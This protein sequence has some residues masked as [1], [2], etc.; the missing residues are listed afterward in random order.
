VLAAPPPS[1]SFG[2]APKARPIPAWGEAP[3]WYAPDPRGL[4][5]RPMPSIPQILLVAFHSILLQERPELILEILLPMMRLLRV[6]ILNQRLQISRTYR[7]RSVSPLPRELRQHRRFGLEPLRRRSLQLRNQLRN[8][9]GSQ[10]PD[11]KMHMVRN[12]SH[13]VALAPGIAND[14]GKVRIQFRT[15]RITQ[16]SLPALRTEDHM[17]HDERK[18]QW[19]R[20]EY[21]S[22]LQPSVVTCNTSWGYAPCWYRSRRGRWRVRRSTVPGTGQRSA[23]RATQSEPG[24]ASLLPTQRH[25]HGLKARY[26]PAW[27]G[28]PMLAIA[29]GL[30]ARH[31]LVSESSELL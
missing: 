3:C 4:K 2:K 26:I 29:R 15:N 9:C 6:D 12:T 21:R 20:Q 25:A 17:H 31:I 5:A 14:R 1:T 13:A 8:I 23:E 30:K 7:E 27:G 19:H 18:R 22:G 16:N 28:S 24:T 10:Q 11:C